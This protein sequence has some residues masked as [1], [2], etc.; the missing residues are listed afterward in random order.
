MGNLFQ[1]AGGRSLRYI[2]IIFHFM[3]KHICFILGYIWDS[4]C[5]MCR[6]HTVPLA[7]SMYSMT[8][9]LEVNIFASICC[10]FVLFLWY[11]LSLWERKG[12]AARYL[13]H[14]P[15]L[16]DQFHLDWVSLGFVSGPTGTSTSTSTTGQ[17]IAHSR[18]P[19]PAGASIASQGL[20]CT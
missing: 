12:Q 7:Y 4:T 19:R 11:H 13:E 9:C 5:Q 10:L 8:L 15:A 14:S 2:S 17:E 3:F 16:A 18:R 20:V 1:G 6:C